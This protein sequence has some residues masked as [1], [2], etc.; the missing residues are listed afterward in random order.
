MARTV[1][2]LL[3]NFTLGGA[4][5]QAVEL[6]LRLPAHG[7]RPIV[8]AADPEGP[9]REKV[10]GA[11]IPIFDLNAH[12]RGPLYSPRFWWT[13]TKA[14]WRIAAIC[15][16]EKVRIL[17]SFLFWQNQLAV[18]ARLLAPRMY[19]VTGR[20]NTGEF[21]D[22]ARHYQAIE[23]FTN[24]FT[25]A[26]VCNS[27]GV[28]DDS[29]R[30][31]KAVGDRWV[32][33][34]NG[35]DVERFAS[36]EKGQLRGRLSISADQIVVG[37]VGNMKRQKRHDIFLRTIAALRAKHPNVIGVIVGR[38]MGEEKSLRALRSEL[39]LDS[40][41]HFVTDCVDPAALLKDFDLF[42][43]TSDHE[44]MPNAILE[45][46][47]AGVPVITRN[48]AGVREFAGEGKAVRAVDSDD[49]AILATEAA[50]LLSDKEGTAAMASAGQERARDSFS[51]DGLA[52]RHAELYKALRH[53]RRVP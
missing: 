24:R 46:M 51:L 35:V 4:E 32:V 42:L 34:P 2:L 3:P 14:V 52:M 45:A 28:L 13:I 48:V 15:R 36:S 39:G 49:P 9:L 30:R 5:T 44:G 12:I 50:A 26:I 7:W 21:K 33:I 41:A 43:L 37:T 19:I 38:D 31:E 17:Q 53:R 27:R 22:A 6:A 16:K 23:N 18:P 40:H 25:H 10:A 29:Q 8:I 11:G 1:A 47:S 20:R